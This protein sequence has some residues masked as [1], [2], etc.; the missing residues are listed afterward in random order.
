MNDY[1]YILFDWNGTLI[2]DLQMNID[3]ENHLLSQRNLPLLPSIEFYL[4][5]FGF[6]IRNFYELCGFDFSKE[7]YFDIA[8]EYG[9]EYK[10]RMKS[11]NL[12]CDVVGALE[13]LKESGYKLVIMSA[14]E[15]NTL[16]SQVDYY[17]ISGYFE[18]VIGNENKLGK[19]KVQ[20]ALD[21][22]T[23]QSIN[24][25][26]VLFVG[27]TVHDSETA[28]AIGCDCF[29][30]ARGHNSKRRLEETGCEVFE[31]LKEIEERLCKK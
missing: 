7:S 14:T 24:A 31:T 8:E 26:D 18:K 19:S 28:K 10:K 6:P 1:K 9:E 11:T 25:E 22:F 17:G 13:A 29:L 3:I 30:V 4:E 23:K 2:D 15:H 21:W 27:D 16:V 20:A 12:F 5:N